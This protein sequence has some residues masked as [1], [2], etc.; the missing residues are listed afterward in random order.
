MKKFVSLMVVL[1]VALVGLS[2]CGSG[3]KTKG[4]S[5]KEENT[6]IVY[7]PNSEDIVNTL[8][9]MFE[10]ETGIKV[11]LVSAVLESY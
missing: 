9:P 2:A 7:S 5:K 3:E 1:T 10:K 6:L 11:E 8:I 4:A